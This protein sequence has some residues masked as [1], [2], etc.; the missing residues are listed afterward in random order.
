MRSFENRTFQPLKGD[1]GIENQEM[2]LQE[3][4]SIQLGIG[5]SLV[6]ILSNHYGLVYEIR[7]L[8]PFKYNYENCTILM[9]Y[10][11]TAWKL[12][13]GRFNAWWKITKILRKYISNLQ[14]RI[15]VIIIDNTIPHKYNI[16]GLLIHCLKW[17]HVMLY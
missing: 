11:V 1:L 7:L 13:D 3:L 14:L 5:P 2:I 10:R 12:W 6:L 17:T 16:F 8:M 9:N 4:S 15:I